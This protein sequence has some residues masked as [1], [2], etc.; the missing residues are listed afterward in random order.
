M[1]LENP[2]THRWC[3]MVYN[4]ACKWLRLKHHMSMILG[5]RT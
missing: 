1:V 5:L 3:E 2:F 4:D